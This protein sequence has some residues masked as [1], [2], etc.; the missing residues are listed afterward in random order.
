MNSLSSRSSAWSSRARAGW[1]SLVL[2]VALLVAA[3]IV[4]SLA[5]ASELVDRNT[6]R[7]R[8][9]VGKGGV[10]MIRYRKRGNTKY[11]FY[12]GAKNAG[13]PR[14]KGRRFKHRRN[15]G[16]NNILP[17]EMK[18]RC[19]AYR[20]PDLPYVVDACTAPDGSHWVL[21]KWARD[22]PIWGGNPA[23]ATKELRLS[24]FTGKPAQIKVWPNWSWRGRYMHIVAQLTYRGRPW[25]AVKFTKWGKVQDAIG[26]NIPIESYNSDMGKGWRRVNS[27]LTHRPSG[28]MC[29]GF[30]P[31]ELPGGGK[32]G[33]GLSRD[34][35]YRLIVPGPGVTPDVIQPFEGVTLAQYSVEADEEINNLIR[36][37]TA[38]WDG[39]HNCKR[40]N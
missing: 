38:G 13:K 9:V 17:E 20:G 1:G 39:P 10:A 30:T 26:R 3:L 37:L 40:V 28:Q 18:N 21:Q 23:K 2:I 22:A 32:S 25:Y 27:V 31:K 35:K 24:H 14:G 5:G 19:R 11:V 7:E 4:P 29:F 33:S 36:D 8:L 6:K 34:N 15:W 12:W 16:P